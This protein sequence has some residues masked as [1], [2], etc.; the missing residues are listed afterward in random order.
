MRLVRHLHA[1]ALAALAAAGCSR[2]R[3]PAPLAGGEADA[4]VPAPSASAAP[5]P[6][7]ALAPAPPPEVETCEADPGIYLYVANVAPWS[8]APLRV[9]AV[10]EKKLVGAL[11]LE[12]ASGEALAR[13]DARMGGPPYHWAVELASPPAGK[14][15]VRFTQKACAAG[16]SEAS[17]DVAVAGKRPW[18][19]TRAAP[20]VA[21]PTRAAWNRDL[22]NVYSAWVERL[23]DAP[24][25]AQ[26]SYAALHEVLRD[27][28]RNFLFDAMG[29]GEDSTNA[30]KLRPDCADLPYFLRGYFAFKHGLPFGL[31]ECTRGGGGRPPSCSGLVTNHDAPGKT[32]PDAVGTFGLYMRTTVAD[33]AHSGSARA[34]FDDPSSDFFP[35]PLTWDAL[36]PGVVYADPYGHVLVVAKRIPQTS[37]RAGVLLAVDGQPDGTVA[38]KRFWRG[39]FLYARQPELGGPGFKRFRP[40]A[41]VGAGL[42][43]LGDAEITRRGHWGEVSHAPGSLDVEAF[44]DAMDDVLSPAPLDPTRALAE[45]LD[46]LE[47]Q[48]KARVTSIEN[49][50]KFL[51][52]GKPVASMPDGPEIFETSG[53][54]EDFSTPSRDLR[55]LIAVDVAKGLPARVARRPERYA[56]P[57]GKPV[58][59]VRRALEQTLAAELS[60][61]AISYTRSDG[62]AQSLTLADVV[63]RAER[64]EMAYNPNDCVELRWGADPGSPEAATCRAHAPA[65][66]RAKMGQYRAWFRERRR[67]ARK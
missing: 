27:P 40:V 41:R 22:E 39:N 17:R 25:D 53:A 64:L 16:A 33:R 51:E 18:V 28:A 46:A 2:A 21:W 35:V 34:P 11:A 29:A 6:S 56:M 47:E 12:S 58:E 32:R 19:P 13:S 55:L 4:S 43:R 62:S 42:A 66:Q 44:Y 3:P 14:V 15:R 57:A 60:R 10:T 30:Q 61:R 20:D 48:V 63:A 38:R 1:L 8:G 24:L 36:R 31:A 67:P 45:I 59:E 23:F 50:R 54:W 65:E 49:G 52:S 5:A 9:L 37:G 7:A 26:L